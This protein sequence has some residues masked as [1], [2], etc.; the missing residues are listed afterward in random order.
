V[1]WRSGAE[2]SPVGPWGEV[3][4]HSHEVG[5]HGGGFMGEWLGRDLS[6]MEAESA[7]PLEMK[8][9]Q[10]EVVHHYR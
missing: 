4:E 6:L 9:S 10:C 1:R 2:R 7:G 8:W 5:G 3:L